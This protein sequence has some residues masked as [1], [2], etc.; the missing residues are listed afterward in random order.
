M[1][2]GSVAPSDM[3]TRVYSRPSAL[4]GDHLALTTSGQDE[5]D[6]RLY[7]RGF[8]RSPRV[9]ACGMLALAD[10]AAADFRNIRA[11][12]AGGRDPV[13]TSDGERLRLESLS[14][15]GG[16]YGR[17]DVEAAGLEGVP[18]GRGTT[19]VDVNPP[20][21]QA[22]TRVGGD[23]PLRLTVGVDE[24]S[25]ATMDGQVVEKRVPLPARWLR[26]LAEVSARA[27]ALDPRMDLPVG[28]AGGLLAELASTAVRRTRWIVPAG[29][30]WRSSGRAVPGAICVADGFRLSVLRPLLPLARTVTVY[31]PPTTDAPA[32]VSGWT[33][34]FGTARFTVLL[35][36]AVMHGFAGD[37]QLLRN[38]TLDTVVADGDLL[39][40]ILATDPALDRVTLAERTGWPAD[41]VAS[42]LSAL[43]TAGQVGYDLAAAAHYHRP[44]P[45]RADLVATLHPRLAAAR[46]LATAG[47]VSHTANG[48]EVTSGERTYLVHPKGHGYACTCAWWARHQGSRGPCKHVVAAT[49]VGHGAGDL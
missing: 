1:T 39:A 16:V 15:C 24:V 7:F 36:D 9:V 11:E 10:I 3:D 5:T 4:N 25:M 48:F 38:L 2:R 32:Q 42:A 22:L 41:R 34:D 28:R 30:T 37:G 44:L 13:V 49:I 17:L 27:A 35:S 20:L 8:M 6:G 23:D 19:N 18:A 26:G 43:A 45:Y 29:R 31:S 40:T 21:Y 47:T 33:L 46:L 14:R 12:R